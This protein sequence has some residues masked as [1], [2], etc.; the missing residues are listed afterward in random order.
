[1]VEGAADPRT[2][3]EG[4]RDGAVLFADSDHK[5]EARLEFFGARITEVRFPDLD[6]SARIQ[7]RSA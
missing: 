2:G 1:V 4:R 7:P 6:T 3:D 5:E